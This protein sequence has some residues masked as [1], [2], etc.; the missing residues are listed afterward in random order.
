[1]ACAAEAGVVEVV[2]V[3]VVVVEDGCGRLSHSRPKRLT[4]NLGCALL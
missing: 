3:V 1:M 4:R 2:V